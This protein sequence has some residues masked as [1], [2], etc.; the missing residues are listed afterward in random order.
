MRAATM[1]SRAASCHSTSYCAMSGAASASA[2]RRNI[3]KM[4]F[5]LIMTFL[6]W[7]A[8]PGD[9]RVQGTSEHLRI[10][11]R[12]GPGAALEAR[13]SDRVTLQLAANEARSRV[14]LRGDGGSQRIR[15]VPLSFSL[16]A[17]ARMPLA[18]RWW[19]GAEAKMLPLSS[20]FETNKAED[21]GHA[22]Q[23]NF[24]PV[25]VMTGVGVRF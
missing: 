21:P 11:P 12:L 22:L 18:R 19:L 20:T 15:V 14:S 3:R 17:G 1:R 6:A 2:A 16:Q 5:G 24:H 4:R 9:G 8:F 23:T 10:A 7:T 25:V 13:V